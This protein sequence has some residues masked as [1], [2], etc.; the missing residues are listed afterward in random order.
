MINPSDFKV[1]EVESGVALIC[2]VCDE[3][4]GGPGW[5]SGFVG[6]ESLA[7]LAGRAWAHI[8]ERHPHAVATVEMWLAAE[9]RRPL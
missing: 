3:A 8:D 9:R 5:F 2:P 4:S 6:G 7:Q 1:G